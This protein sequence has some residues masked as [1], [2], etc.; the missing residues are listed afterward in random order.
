MSV[1]ASV[2]VSFADEPPDIAIE[3]LYPALI[4]CFAIITIGWVCPPRPWRWITADHFRS[5]SNFPTHC[6]SPSRYRN[7]RAQDSLLWIRLSR[8]SWLSHGATFKVHSRVRA[9]SVSFKWPEMICLMAWAV[10]HALIRVK[11]RGGLGI[12]RDMLVFE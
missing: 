2:S 8:I 5:P 7:F 9:C 3:N 1:N 11:S 10:N 12:T 4:Q 6:H